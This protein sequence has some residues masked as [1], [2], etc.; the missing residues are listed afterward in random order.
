[1]KECNHITKGLVQTIPLQPKQFSKGNTDVVLIQIPWLAQP[2]NVFSERIVDKVQNILKCSDS[3]LSS[4]S[5]DTDSNH[6]LHDFAVIDTTVNDD[7][8]DKEEEAASV[9]TFF[10]RYH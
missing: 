3:K 2:E 9:D 5:S 1:M 4:I 6:S 10:G 7:D 8:S